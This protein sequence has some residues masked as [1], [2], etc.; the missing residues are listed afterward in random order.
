MEKIDH[1]ALVVS[2]VS[3]ELKGMNQIEIV[4]LNIKIM[5]NF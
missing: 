2:N 5:I 4:K 3:K 1:I